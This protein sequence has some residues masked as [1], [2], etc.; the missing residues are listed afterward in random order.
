[1]IEPT[2]PY[3]AGPLKDGGERVAC[4]QWGDPE[5]FHGMVLV[6][7]FTRQ[8]RDFDGLAQALLTQANGAVRVVFPEMVGRA[9]SA[10]LG[11]PNRCQ[12]PLSLYATDI[13]ALIGVAPA[14]QKGWAL[15][16]QIRRLVPSDIGPVPESAALAR[17]AGD[18]EQ[19][20][21]HGSLA[22]AAAARQTLAAGFGPHSTQHSLA[23]SRHMLLPA[24]ARTSQ[25]V[26][27][28]EFIGRHVGAGPVPLQYD[29]AVAMPFCSMTV[30]GAAQGE[31]I[32]WTLC[33][34]VTAQTSLLRAAMSGLLV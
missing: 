30:Q 13:L 1:M 25:G 4:W 32:M 26:A 5:N 3:V 18:V 14:G 27:K 20:D 6:H 12:L 11:D 17:I 7:R 9:E 8:R 2:L 10:W 23:L 16:V 34:T 21:R 19:V 28:T 24:A 15:P 29:P 22:D 31:A 33:D